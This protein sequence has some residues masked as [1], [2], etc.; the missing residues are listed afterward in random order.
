MD[1]IVEPPTVM[2]CG[3]GAIVV[4]TYELAED[5]C[6]AVE[7]VVEVEGACEDEEGGSEEEET[8]L[9]EP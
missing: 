7:V 2:T 8:A 3:D 1:T 4:T 6:V 9:E 5:I